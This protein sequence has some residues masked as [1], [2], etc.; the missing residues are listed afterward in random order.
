ME[1]TIGFWYLNM[2]ST[3]YTGWQAGKEKE[4]DWPCQAK[5]AIQ[6]AIC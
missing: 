5:N 1:E 3:F 2:V 4:E 6:Q